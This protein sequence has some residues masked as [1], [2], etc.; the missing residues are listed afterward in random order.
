MRDRHK[1]IEVREYH[2]TLDPTTGE[3]DSPHHGVPYGTTH[4]HPTDDPE[5]GPRS[6]GRGPACSRSGRGSGDHGHRWHLRVLPRVA[7]A[8]QVVVRC[9]RGTGPG[10][11]TR[12]VVVFLNVAT[13]TSHEG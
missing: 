10:Q 4:H 12:T 13:T 11:R 7:A 8:S 9:A 5:H 6:G 1:V 2:M 3:D